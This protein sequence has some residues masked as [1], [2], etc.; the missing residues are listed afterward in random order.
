MFVPA[1][2]Q[3]QG[4]FQINA[5]PADLLVHTTACCCAGCPAALSHCDPSA[6]QAA[7]SEMAC[8]SHVP[9]ALRL[10]RPQG[11]TVAL[12]ALAL[13]MALVPVLALAWA[14]PLAPDMEMRWVPALL[15]QCTEA[16]HSPSTSCPRCGSGL[17]ARPHAALRSCVSSRCTVKFE[18]SV[19]LQAPASFS[20]VSTSENIFSMLH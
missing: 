14:A 10:G 20:P 9:D 18:A 8:G 11:P 6:T 17:F 16:G 19:A 5:L 12:E 1:S 3:L 2:T 15:Q 13:V 7:S 4:R